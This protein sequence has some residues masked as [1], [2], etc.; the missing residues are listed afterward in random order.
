MLTIP[1]ALRRLKGNL[2]EA[3]PESLLRQICR[4]LG[5]PF[6]QR[7]LTPVVT[8][9][10]FLQQVLH[11]NTA[12]GNLRH[13][14]GLDFTDSAYCRARARLP[15]AF[16]RR[17]QRAVLAGCQSAGAADAAARWHGHRL[18]L[19]DGSSFSMPDTPALQEAFGQPG[20]QAQGCGFPTA[21]LLVLF[22]AHT[23]FLLQALPAPLRTHDLSRAALVHRELRP[24]D[25]L[26]GDRAFCSYAHLALCRRRKLHG[27]FRAHQRLLIDFRPHRRHTHPRRAAKEPAG[28][29]RSHWL[30][31]LGK[32]DQLVEYFKPTRHPVWMTAADYARLPESLVVREVRFR[33]RERGRRVRAV[34]LVTTLLDARRYPAR[35]LAKLYAQRWQVETDLRHLKQTLGMDV[36]RCETVPGVVKEL[37]MFAVVYNLVRRVMQEASRR[38]GVGPGRISFVDA[39][40]WLRQARPGEALPRLRVNPERPGRVEPRARKRRPKEYDLLTKPR[41]EL[42]KALLGKRRAA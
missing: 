6:R 8:T 33:V 24:G 37:L 30:R 16:F 5:R 13:L 20:A 38:Q 9:Y 17:L 11:G 26:L 10:L 23:G 41:A 34:T 40:R 2:A 32:R 22:D 18:L 25:L 21:H 4:D 15:L 14:S 1:H 19:L 12:V 27:L 29:P 3:V 28:R 7:T 35:A 31:R 36:L 42:R 39:W